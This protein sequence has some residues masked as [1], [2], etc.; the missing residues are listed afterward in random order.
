[1]RDSKSNEKNRPSAE[2]ASSEAIRPFGKI[3]FPDSDLEDLKRRVLATRWPDKEL[4]SD[5]SQGVQ[6]ETMKALAKHWGTNYNWRK[7]E[8]RLNSYPQFLTTIDGLDIHFIHVRSK[9][10]NALPLIITHGWPGSV[11]EQLKIIDALTDP[12]AHG[13]KAEDAFD[14]VVPSIPGFGFSGKPTTTG[15]DAVRVA[16]T[17]ITLMKR[18]G[19]TKFAAQGGDWGAIITEQMALLGAPELVG[20]HVNMACVLTPEI[21]K[22]VVLGQPVPAGM[23][24]DE[25]HAWERLVLFFSK[26]LGYALEMGNRPQTLYGISDSPVGLAAWF[27]DHDISSMEMISRTFT[28]Q[29]EGISK[30]DF[31][32]NVTLAWLTNTGISGARLYWE[33]KLA[34]FDTKNVRIPVAVSVF[35]DEIYA[36]P[37]SWAEK[38]YSKLIHYN[39]LPKGGHFAAFEQPQYMIDEIRTGLRSLR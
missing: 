4:V 39:K 15:W 37:R 29:N 1:M 27:M 3:H 11:A 33:N 13:G 28:G 7:V 6:L 32:D 30:D 36:A 24:G 21:S 25:K 8:D 12:T 23:T 17:W 31:L 26:G 19:Y 38:A 18:L 35:P 16:R 22:A 34:F 2:T 10:P 20:I 14:L 9:N 5:S